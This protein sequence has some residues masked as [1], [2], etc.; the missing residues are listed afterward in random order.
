MFG[1]GTIHVP[2][3]L[4]SGLDGAARDELT[5]LGLFAR[6]RATD[7]FEDA[8]Y[9]LAQ[10]ETEYLAQVVNQGEEYT[11]LV[12]ARGRSVVS[13]VRNGERVLV[14]AEDD[15]KSPAAVL[16]EKLPAY[17]PAQVARI[18]LS[19]HEFRGADGYLPDER[20]RTALAVDA[21]FEASSFGHGEIN[22]SIRDRGRKRRVA[23]GVL[24]YRDLAEGRVAFD[25]SGDERNRYIK[26]MPG[27]N[28]QM[29]QQ[30]AALRTSLG[31]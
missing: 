8:V 16:I 25:V 29:A 1:A 30:V 15:R 4:A 14:T 13:A 2:E 31:R 18:S 21:L 20:S 28:Q 12:G 11:A 19:Q 7:E 3:S 6:G 17:R 27:G 24:L 9:A 10:P 23:D 22:V 26:V 5:R